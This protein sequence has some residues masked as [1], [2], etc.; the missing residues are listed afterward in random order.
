MSTVLHVNGDLTV[1][2]VHD[3]KNQWLAAAEEFAAVT[4]DLSNTVEVDGAGLQL[5]LAMA[6]ECRQRDIDLYI[7]QPPQALQEAMHLVNTCDDFQC[8]PQEDVP[9]E[10]AAV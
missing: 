7:K 2:T 9:E 1:Y 10:E 3:L 4:L 8:A 6:R 5:L